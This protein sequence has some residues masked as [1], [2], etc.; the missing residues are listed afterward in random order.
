MILFLRVFNIGFLI[1]KTNG[2]TNFIITRG[3]FLENDIEYKFK[4]KTTEYYLDGEIEG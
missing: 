3:F 1:L 2:H 4:E